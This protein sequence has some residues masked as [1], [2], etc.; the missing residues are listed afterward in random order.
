MVQVN[1]KR[2]MFS[3]HCLVNSVRTLGYNSKPR[4]DSLPS[5]TNELVSLEYNSSPINAQCAHRSGQRAANMQLAGQLATD[6][7]DFCTGKV[8]AYRAAKIN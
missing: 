7:P 6:W 8:P 5:A 1:K 4:Y 2:R 3:K